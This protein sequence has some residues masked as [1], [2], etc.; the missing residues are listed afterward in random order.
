MA[1]IPQRR[2]FMQR[3]LFV[4]L[5]AFAVALSGSAAG[6]ASTRSN[7]TKPPSEAKMHTRDRHKQ[8]QAHHG[9]VSQKQAMSSQSGPVTGPILATPGGPVNM[10]AG[11]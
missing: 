3:R 1:R 9:N 2:T 4:P 6:Q 7:A 11:D 10:D 5:L 8:R